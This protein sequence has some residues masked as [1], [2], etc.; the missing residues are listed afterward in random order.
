MVLRLSKPI[1]ARTKTVT[2]RWCKLEWLQMSDTYRA[3]R[4]KARHKLDTCY[5]CG[6]AFRDGEMMALAAFEEQV[7]NRTL[8][9]VCGGKLL[10]SE[11]AGDGG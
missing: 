4:R 5:W 8:C 2:A 11:A 6:H 1:P 10:A 9:Q 7:G 3:I